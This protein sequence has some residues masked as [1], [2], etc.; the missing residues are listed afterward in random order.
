MRVAASAAGLTLAA[1]V[2]GEAA[3]RPPLTTEDL[4]ALRSV[5]DVQLSPDATRVAY[6]VHSYDRPG[7]PSTDIWIRDLSAAQPVRLA[8]GVEPR[9]APTGRAIAFLAR[10]GL[11][12]VDIAGGSRSTRS[13]S[14][15]L[16]VRRWRPSARP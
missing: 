7:R 4:T 13:G 11:Y 8:A 9:W 2:L 16:C 10:G 12:V 5:S 1:I 6:T 14:R 3:G 15:T